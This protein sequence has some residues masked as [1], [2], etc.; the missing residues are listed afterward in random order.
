MTS[1]SAEKQLDRFL[2]AFTPEIA[3]LARSALARLRKRLPN[4]IELVYDNYNALACGFA[5]NERASDGIF[6]I[7]VYPKNINF[8]F[9]QGAKLP[10][11]DGMLHGAGSLVRYVPL[12]DEKTLDRADVKA[13]MA[14]AMEMAKVPFDKK[15][16]Y[17]LVIKSVSTKQRPRRPA[18]AKGKK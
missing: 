7:A 11:P 6:S 18:A 16:K 4:A 2:D 15:T 3:A 5:P 10:D 8:F 13:M 17:R 9:L 14:T 12:E 1:E